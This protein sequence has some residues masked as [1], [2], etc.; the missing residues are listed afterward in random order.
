MTQIQDQ[1]INLTGAVNYDS[2]EFVRCVL[3]V[4]SASL[5]SAQFDNCLFTNCTYTRDGAPCANRR[6][7]FGA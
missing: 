2:V 1:T 3:N 5:T 4:V 6:K 7:M